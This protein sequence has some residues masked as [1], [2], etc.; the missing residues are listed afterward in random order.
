MKG[1]SLTDKILHFTPSWFA[2]I[3]GTGVVGILIFNLP[4]G[5]QGIRTTVASA[6]LILNIVIFM[7]FLLASIARYALFPQIWM[8]MIHEPIQSLFLGCFPM[9]LATIISATVS[10]SLVHTRLRSLIMFLWGLWWFDLALSFASCILLPYIM[11]TRHRILWEHHNATWLL[12][13]VPP[14]VA[15]SCGAILASALIDSNPEKARITV[16]ASC[17]SLA[18]GLSVSMMIITTYLFRLFAHGFPAAGLV[19]SVLVPLG[20][21]GQG[22]YAL[23]LLS[24]HFNTLISGLGVEEALYGKIAIALATAG[25]LTLW[26]I[27]SWLGIIAALGLVEATYTSKIHFRVN[28]WGM[29]FPLGVYSLLTIQL[30]HE[31]NLQ[32]FRICG[33]ILSAITGLLWLG[34]SSKT[35]YLAFDG[36][37]FIAP[38]LDDKPHIRPWFNASP[39]YTKDEPGANGTSD[40]ENAQEETAH[41]EEHGVVRNAQE[42]KQ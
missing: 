26:S 9:A 7:T 1:K 8:L 13:V 35:V 18:V 23:L 17:A 33:T 41:T 10:I 28:F 42:T 36:T 27:G 29:V 25:A 37:I 21:C 40:M 22:G 3:M 20:P 30:G 6:F 34:I 14:I 4:F 2:V 38:C 12:P 16:A 24:K 11:I 32:F 15:A 5:D 31:L 19:V 39:K